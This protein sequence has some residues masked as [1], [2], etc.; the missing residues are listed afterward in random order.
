MTAPPRRKPSLPEPAPEE[1]SIG[2]ILHA[3]RAGVGAIAVLLAVGLI[4]ALVWSRFAPQVGS[5][6]DAVLHP[7]RIEL[8]GKAPWVRAD[9][10][11]EALRN[12]SLDHGLPLTDPELPNRL[13]RAFDMHPWVRRVVRV[14][15]R[16]P[17]AAT[18]EVQCRE[19]AAMVSVAGGLLAVDAEG[20]VLPSAD[21]TPEAAA[22]YPRL[23]G[24]E[25]SPQGPEGAVWGD[26]AVEEGA[27]LAHVIQPEWRAL[28]LSECRAGMVDAGDVE[29]RVWEF[30]GGDGTLY[31]FGAAPG[32]EEGGEATAAVKVARLKAL[33]GKPSAS[34]TAKIDLR[35]EP[36]TSGR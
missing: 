13:A 12:S 24:I 16:H 32:R 9:I 25:S 2:S 30:V 15:L 27:A 10:R 22:S 36:A 7:D 8:R 34:A 29:R 20:V 6:D 28:G 14:E 26:P 35:D 17:A 11:A 21:F 4:G 19:P 31:V 23:A 3:R 1:R 18:V 5:A 33:V